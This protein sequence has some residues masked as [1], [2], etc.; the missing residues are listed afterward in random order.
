MIYLVYLVILNS[1]TTVR[2][3]EEI[4][5]PF[6]GNVEFNGKVE[7]IQYP[8]GKEWLPEGKTVSAWGD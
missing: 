3:F 6:N 1:R 2:T 8:E 7:Y 5:K 4:R